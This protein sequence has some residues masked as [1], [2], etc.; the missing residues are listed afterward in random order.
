M[1]RIL[2]EIISEVNNAQSLSVL[3]EK[4]LERSITLLNFDGGGIY[5]VDLGSRTPILFIHKTS[6]QSSLLKSIMFLSIRAL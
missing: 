3:L 4:V 2:N 5:F 1:L 6:L